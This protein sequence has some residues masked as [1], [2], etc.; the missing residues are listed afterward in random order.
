MIKVTD[1]GARGNATQQEFTVT[2]TRVPEPLRIVGGPPPTDLPRDVRD[3]L[4]IWLAG[5]QP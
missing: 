3:A 5:N 4:K 1:T 2:I